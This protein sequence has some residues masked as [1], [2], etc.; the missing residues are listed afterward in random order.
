M[1][2]P[3]SDSVRNV[4]MEILRRQGALDF[5]DMEND[6]EVRL[7]C[8]F[9]RTLIVQRRDDRISI[10]WGQ[11]PG[12]VEVE[13]YGMAFE[14]ENDL[15]WRAV[16]VLPVMFDARMNTSA[17]NEQMWDLS[18]RESELRLSAMKLDRNLRES[19]YITMSSRDAVRVTARIEKQR[20]RDMPAA[21]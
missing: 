20:R 14:I 18:A 3:Q 6:F 13:V 5:I 17:L 1:T 15:S 16:S 21:A 19:L 7:E 12:K 4:L 8:R 10:V 2:S 9:E 11:I